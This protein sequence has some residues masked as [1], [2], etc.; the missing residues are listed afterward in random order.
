M[1]T[2]SVYK[3]GTGGIKLGTGSITNGSASLT[4]YTAT[5]SRLTGKGRNV[6]VAITSSTHIGQS[7]RTRVVTDGGTT[8]TLADKNPFAT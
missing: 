3:S 5:N 1:S 7:F 4:G 8:L 2:V 6:T